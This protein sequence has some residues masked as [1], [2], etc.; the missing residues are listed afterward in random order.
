MI[1]ISYS[2]LRENIKTYM[3]KVANDFETKLKSTEN[4]YEKELYMLKE[5]I[6]N[7]L[8]EAFEK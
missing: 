7:Y 4:S 3:D 5:K 1:T 8:E 6:N 2:K